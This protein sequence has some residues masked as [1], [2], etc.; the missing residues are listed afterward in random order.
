MKA[1]KKKSTRM[2]DKLEARYMG[3]FTIA[4]VLGRGVFRLQDGEKILK[5]VV[6]AT[7][8]KLFVENVTPV[9]VLSPKTPSRQQLPPNATSPMTSI[10]TPLPAGSQSAVASRSVQ[11][12]PVR[13][14]VPGTPS[15]H[16]IQQ[17]PQ[18]S[19]SS[20]IDF[21]SPLPVSSQSSVTPRSVYA[22]VPWLPDLNLNED[23][24]M[25]LTDQ[26]H[27]MS[28]KAADAVN[29]M[30]EG[31]T[32]GW[33]GNTTQTCQK[34]QQVLG[35]FEAQPFETIRILHDAP[36]HWVA[37]ACISGQVRVADSLGRPLSKSV[38]D[39]LRQLFPAAIDNRSKTLKVSVMPCP[40]QSNGR[41]C[42]FYATAACFEWACGNDLPRAW[43]E[44][45][46]RDHLRN[47]FGAKE[48]RPFPQLSIKGTRG[49]RPQP[50]EIKI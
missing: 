41:D 31:N 20:V 40:R 12:S 15:R 47:C 50:K 21:P 6:N 7:N 2:G 44:G 45:Q 3:P 19:T 27:L 42:G 9:P 33:E 18:I 23:D 16:S 48:C 30:L 28:D 5:S 29:R 25:E 24:R 43:D 17:L 36:L 26:R 4:E 49:R 37:C 34:Y 14:T 35:G 22:P 13:L 1:N 38:R 32:S 11:S 8:L 10:T 39:Q 46:M